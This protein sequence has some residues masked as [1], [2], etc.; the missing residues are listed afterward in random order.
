RTHLRLIVILYPTPQ[1]VDALM[2]LELSSVVD[3]DLNL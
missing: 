1:T 3:V 2:T